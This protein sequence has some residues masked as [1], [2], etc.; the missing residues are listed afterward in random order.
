[1][2]VT[3]T[4]TGPT[5]PSNLLAQALNVEVIVLVSNNGTIRFMGY[6][7]IINKNASVTPILKN[8]SLMK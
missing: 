2:G 5:W 7:F 1:M 4:I 6:I 8:I 3:I